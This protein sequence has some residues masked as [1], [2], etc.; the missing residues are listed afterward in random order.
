[1]SVTQTWIHLPLFTVSHGSA[2]TVVRVT[3]Q[4]DGIWQF[5]VSELRNSEPID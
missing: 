4:V 2:Y 5:W 1:M 3:Q